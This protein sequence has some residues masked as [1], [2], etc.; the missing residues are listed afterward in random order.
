MLKVGDLIVVLPM[1][2]RPYIVIGKHEKP[3]VWVL[4]SAKYNEVITMNREFIEVL[5]AA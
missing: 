2:W 3:G 1:R 5:S 4:H